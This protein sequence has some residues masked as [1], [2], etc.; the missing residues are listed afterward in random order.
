MLSLILSDVIGDPLHII[1]SG[2][3][4]PS[5]TTPSAVR[6]LLSIYLPKIPKPLPASVISALNGAVSSSQTYPQTSSSLTSASSSSA[7]FIS[8]GICDV[9]NVLIGNNAVATKAAECAAAELG[10][11][12]IVWS[13]CVEGEAKQVGELYAKLA[14]I[15]LHHMR[16]PHSR[17]KLKQ[18]LDLL[19]QKNAAVIF[20]NEKVKS[21]FSNLVDHLLDINSNKLCLISGGEPTV[22]VNGN[23]V[24]GRNQE[25]A[26]SFACHIHDHLVG[27]KQEVDTRGEN[28]FIGNGT[29][30]FG[31]LG[32]DGQDGPCDSAG[33]VVD[34]QTWAQALKQGLDPEDSLLNN[35]SNTFFSQLNCGQL[36]IKTGLTGTNVMDLHALLL[37][38]DV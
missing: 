5:H 12:V 1:A 16:Q 36:L 22:T 23:G 35:D 30:V 31:C 3:T 8:R 34:I 11:K 17:H 2:P 32:T 27:N 29:L 38:F 18:Q 33:A 14:S 4:V 6:T 20:P 15:L 26:L 28:S 25:M 37:S 9:H 24:G 10:Y 13:H 19:T 7:S 21:N